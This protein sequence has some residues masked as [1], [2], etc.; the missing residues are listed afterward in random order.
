MVHGELAIGRR[1]RPWMLELLL[2][3]AVYG[4]YEL[5]RALTGVHD[6]V[7]VENA[8]NLLRFQHALHL[9][10]EH[11][12]NRLFTGHAVLAV[13]AV[14]L[15]AVCHYVVTPVVLV[16]LWRAHRP[17]YRSARG[18]LVLATLL[19]LLGFWLAPMAPPRSFDSFTDTMA[20]WSGIGWWSSAG[21]VPH[22]L[23]S[24]TDQF[25]AM[26]S[27]HV[28]WA[29]WCGWVLFRYADHRWLRILGV[30]YPAVIWVVVIGTANHYFLDG[31]AGAFVI[32]LSGAVVTAVTAL[33]A[34]WLAA[35]VI[36]AAAAHDVVLPERH[37]RAI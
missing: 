27:L 28:G 7:A 32:A 31:L 13:P 29:V 22:G 23:Q 25:A 12:L 5:V 21:S 17:Q 11:A 33:R 9:S 34:R 37:T 3:A 26:P 1:L 35:R 30:A 24:L 15:Y 16:W 20:Q 6:S 18:I 36:S 19:G 4:G 14:Y 2:L 8:R 10:P